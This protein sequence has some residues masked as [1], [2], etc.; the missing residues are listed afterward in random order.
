[1]S[2]PQDVLHDTPSAGIALALVPAIALVA[3]RL[4]GLRFFTVAGLDQWPLSAL[5][6]AMTPR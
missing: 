6:E 2:G 5:P 1:M 3:A 4:M